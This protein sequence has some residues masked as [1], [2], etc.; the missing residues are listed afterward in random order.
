MKIESAL[1]NEL[2]T[3]QLDVSS[4]LIKLNGYICLFGT[5]DAGL[6]RIYSKSLNDRLKSKLGLSGEVKIYDLS[7]FR[8]FTESL[9]INN[10]EKT[11]LLESVLSFYAFFQKSLSF[12]CIGFLF[13][14]QN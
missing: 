6:N 1:Y 10:N 9:F 14:C 3:E 12:I 2:S 11:F 7:I 13:L 8:S 5:N 4:Q